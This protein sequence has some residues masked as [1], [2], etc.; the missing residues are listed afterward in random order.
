MLCECFLLQGVTDVV[1]IQIADGYFLNR[2]KKGVFFYY[3]SSF[4]SYDLSQLPCPRWS[5]PLASTFEISIHFTKLNLRNIRTMVNFQLLGELLVIYFWNLEVKR[6]VRGLVQTG[7]HHHHHHRQ[8]DGRVVR[9]RW[10]NSTNRKDNSPSAT[11]SSS[12]SSLLSS[13]TWK[14]CWL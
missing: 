11:C 13:K 14:S 9:T 7:N 10:S 6:T 12:S 8:H 1:S 2:R 3:Y 5:P 4:S